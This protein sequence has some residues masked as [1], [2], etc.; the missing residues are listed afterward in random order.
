MPNNIWLVRWVDD[1]DFYYIDSAW[2]TKQL[3]D[4]RSK[5]LESQFEKERA[6][7]IK[8]SYCPIHIKTFDSLS[9]AEREVGKYCSMFKSINWND[10]IKYCDCENSSISDL[11]S[12]T[13]LSPTD[14]KLNPYA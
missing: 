10:D 12:K 14:V 9:D 5:Q 7:A 2:T 8:C 4:E 6:Q 3:A 13:V 11:D 1:S